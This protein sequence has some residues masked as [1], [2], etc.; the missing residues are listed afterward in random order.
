MKTAALAVHGTRADFK[1]I[2]MYKDRIW[3]L[4]TT[5]IPFT[6]FFLIYYH[7]LIWKLV[8]DESLKATRCLYVFFLLL[9]LTKHNHNV[10]LFHC[11]IK[12]QDVGPMQKKKNSSGVRTLLL[13]PFLPINM[14]ILVFPSFVVFT[15]RAA[16]YLA[17][18]TPRCSSPYTLL[19]YDFCSCTHCNS[20]FFSHCYCI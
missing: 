11:L 5:D 13:Q 3:I 10:A 6:G 4:N 12:C 18:P 16:L 17:P 8:S 2:T 15:P 20:S 14:L 9:S 19:I 7:Q 1:Q